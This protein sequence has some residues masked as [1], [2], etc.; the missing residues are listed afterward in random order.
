MFLTWHS[1]DSVAASMPAGML[2]FAIMSMFMNTAGYVS[3]FVAQYHGAGQDERV[4]RVMWQALSI[5]VIGAVINLS[6]VPGAPVFFR[7]VGHDPAVQ[8][9]EVAFFTVL[10]LG[11]FPA[12]MSTALPEC[13]RGSDV[14]VR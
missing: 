6:L 14:P 12:V 13:S 9:E 1:S 2:N 5:A 10:C 8:I 4:G 3:T 11:V 7:W